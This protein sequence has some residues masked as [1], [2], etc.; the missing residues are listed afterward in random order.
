V[1]EEPIDAALRA[2]ESGLGLVVTKEDLRHLFNVMSANP[3]PD[4]TFHKV[5]G[6]VFMIQRDLDFNELVYDKEQITK[7]AW[8][9]LMALMGEVGAEETKGHYF[10]RANNYYPKLFEAFQSL[11]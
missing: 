10:P 4:D 5:L 1:N 11:M 8:V 3:M 7:F 6:H 2:L 9:P